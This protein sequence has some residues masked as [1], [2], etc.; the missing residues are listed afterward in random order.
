[1][2]RWRL[3]LSSMK[4]GVLLRF[5]HVEQKSMACSWNFRSCGVN[6]IVATSFRSAMRRESWS[7]FTL[8]VIDNVLFVGTREEVCADAAEFIRRVAVV[9]GTLNEIDVNLA[10]D[11]DIAALAKQAQD[12]CGVHIDKSAS[13]TRRFPRSE[14]RGK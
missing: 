2:K 11:A 9:G 7:S 10:R 1:M 12:W 8:S 5:M 13:R 3:V 6:R 14:D 4:H